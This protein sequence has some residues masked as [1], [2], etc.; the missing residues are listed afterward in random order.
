MFLEKTPFGYEIQTPTVTIF[1]GSVNA[2]VPQL[3]VAYPQLKFVRVK[4]IH[5]ESVVQTSGVESDLLVEADAHFSEQLNLALCVITADCV[6]LFFYDTQSGLIAA[7]HAGWRG[8]ASRI[9]PKTIDKL[10][11]FGAQ[12]KNIEVVIGPHIQKNSFEVGTDVSDQILSSLHLSSHDDCTQ[13]VAELNNQKLKLDLNLVVQTQLQ[14]S[15]IQ[16]DKVFCLFIDT[17]SNSEFHS[18]RRDKERAGRQVS[19]I[20]R[21]V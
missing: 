19:F 15:G 14:Q 11:E 13:Y 7:V 16:S 10:L 12:A 4:Q 6:P 5:G 2:Q 21:K 9:I 18:H 17:Y 8:V 20:T 3:K 1:L